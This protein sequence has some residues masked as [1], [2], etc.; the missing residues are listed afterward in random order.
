MHEAVNRKV[1]NPQVDGSMFFCRENS[2]GQ[3][4]FSG[5]EVAGT[6]HECL[7]VIRPGDGLCE[8]RW[9]FALRWLEIG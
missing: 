5:S 3:R 7:I 8:S 9:E 2:I 4:S 1:K 6:S